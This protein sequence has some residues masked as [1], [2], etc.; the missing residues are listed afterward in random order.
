MFSKF[1]IERPV[2]ANVLAIV[3]MLLGGVALLE[4]PVAQYPEITPPTV[5][6]STAY[7][8]ASPE[9]IIET[10]AAPIEQQVNG[11]ERMLY[12]SSKSASDG[13]YTLTITFEVGTNLDTATMLVQNRVNT[14]LSSLPQEVQRQGINVKK[15]S[16]AILLVIDLISP[17]GTYDDLFLSNYATLRIK[18]ELAR[19]DGVGDLSIVGADD[20]GMRVWLDPD[21]LKS[22]NLSAQDVVNALSQQN[23]QV[24]SGMLGQPPTPKDQQFQLTIQT[25][26]R[27]VTTEQ[28]GDII[29]KSSFNQTGKVVRVRDVARVELGAKTYTLFGQQNGQPAACIPIYLLP[30][31]NAL[32]VAQKVR[33]EIARLS[34][35][36]PPG[37]Q[38]AIPFDTTL[39]VSRAIDDVYKTLIEAAVL[40]LVVIMVFLQNWRAMLV[41]ATTVPVTILGA[42]V[43]MSALG[44]SVNLITLFGIILAIGIVVDDA[45]IVVEGAMHHMEQG[46]KPK[47]AA[48][49]AMSELFGPIIGITLVLSAV[50]LPV[51][52]LPGI[53]GQIYRQFALVIASTA[54]ISAINA[55][56]L[57]P[58]QC[59]LWLKPR[60]TEPGAFFRGFNAVYQRFENVYTRGVTFMVGH[61]KLAMLIYAGLI[62]A[63]LF[64]FSSLPTGFLPD[65]DQGYCIMSV[66]LPA[67]AS[68]ER[69][70]EVASQINAMLPKVPGVANWITFG[71]MSILDNANQSN[72]L[73]YFV[74]Y[75]DWSAR[76]KDETQDA[77]LMNIRRGLAQ[78]QDAAAFAFIPPAIQGLGQAG[79]FEMVVQDM[80]NLG[81]SALENAL[82]ELIIAG[83]TQSGLAGLNTTF[84]AS[85]PQIWADINRTQAMT[86]GV[87]IQDLFSTLQTYLGSTYVNDF[88]LF[89]RTYQVRAQADTN[90]RQQTRDIMNLQ[91]RNNQGNMVPL[92]AVISVRDIVGPSI[93]TRY[94]LYT[95]ASVFGAAAPGFSSGEALTLMEQLSRDKLPASMGISWTN[96]AYQEKKVGNEAYFIFALAVLLVYLVLAAQYE[97]WFLPTSVIMVVPLALL[98]TAIAVYV[99]NMDNNVYTQ[100]GV[101]L[102]IALASKNAILIVEFARELREKGMSIQEAAVHSARL[103][104]RP[105]L[106]TSFAFILGV[107]PLLSASG[108]GGASQRAVGTAVFGGM[109]AST[110]LAVMVVPVFYVV[111]QGIIERFYPPEEQE[112]EPAPEAE[113]KELPPGH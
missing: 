9:V 96:M 70:R 90:Y 73:T 54:L 7:P 42:F 13:S 16:T 83:H 6:V 39:F 34:K 113:A 50:F 101:V 19:L 98:G 91:V 100:V 89:G 20:Y 71:G 58:T 15:K 33:T 110:L 64:F 86:Y 24:A 22:L 29:V 85:T 61:S 72:M 45:I 28:F 60:T 95:G 104:F 102:L 76:G 111:V 1:F 17:D 41:P 51:A 57:K 56:T 84:S 2:L 36:F 87:A 37:L 40:V 30:G 63:T 12:M 92:G 32:N 107:V 74:I 4:L 103:R 27:L 69:T 43:A 38:Y 81:P 94:N 31:A 88:N 99:R 67:A 68:Q 55:A 62:G 78:I 80:G 49:T 10:V 35:D 53:T 25:Q 82:R 52:F 26:G 65:E 5:Q 46:Q 79:G 8:G 18:D 109:L 66:Q 44:F 105:I 14:A 106:M 93:L 47:Q 77:I 75:K 21:K 11:V 59:A 97:S 108:A 23:V 3:M 48:I 112:H